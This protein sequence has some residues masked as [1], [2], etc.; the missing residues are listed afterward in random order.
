MNMKP[1]F[2]AVVSGNG[3]FPSTVTWTVVPTGMGSIVANQS[4]GNENTATYTPP[5]EE[6]QLQGFPSVAITA[7][8]ADGTTV[9]TAT[10]NL[11]VTSIAY[12]APTGQND[13]AAGGGRA[14]ALRS[15][16][17]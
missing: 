14:A 12:F 11:G 1:V 15:E 16:G 10:V 7:T 8:A 3:T 6:A 2:M 9:G 5:Q 13:Q 4:G 17:R